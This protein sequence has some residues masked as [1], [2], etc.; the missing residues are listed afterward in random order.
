MSA[1][2]SMACP[3]VAIDTSPDPGIGVNASI[4]LMNTYVPG[5]FLKS[6]M[7]VRATTKCAGR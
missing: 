6:G 3:A 2:A 5:V 7:N 4:R 1:L